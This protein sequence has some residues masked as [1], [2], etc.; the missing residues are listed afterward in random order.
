MRYLL[1]NNVLIHYL[2][3]SSLAEH[4]EQTY[5]PLVPSPTVTPLLSAV[6]LG[7]L[8]SLS[9]QNSWGEPRKRQLKLLTNKFLIVDINI[10]TIINRYAE[11]DAFSQNK[12]KNR[13]LNNSARNMGKNDLWIAATASVLDA[14]LLT[15]DKDFDHLNNEFLNVV[16][17]NQTLS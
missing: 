7:E 13:P 3:Q 11:I 1:D 2:R 15:T 4:I 14:T 12:L 9:L 5:Q 16:W 6:I 8:E 17:F 10:K